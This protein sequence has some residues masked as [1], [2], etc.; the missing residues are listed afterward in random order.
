MKK[1]FLLTSVPLLIAGAWA[2]METPRRIPRTIQGV[3]FT[4]E[5][6]E[7]ARVVARDYEWYEP[8]DMA[9]DGSFTF[10][11]IQNWTGEGENRAALV[12]QW[13]DDE[14]EAAIVFGY[15]WDGVATGADMIR[16][17]VA[18]NPRL[19]ALI[20]YTNVS[21]P[22]DPNGGYTINGF[23]WDRDN[24]GEIALQDAKDKKIYTV[25]NGLFIHPRGYN[26]EVGGSSDYDY[27]DWSST[28]PD[29][30]WGAGWYISYWSYWVKDDMESKFGY[31]GWGASGR[32]LQD[33][34]WDGWN[35]SVDMIPSD[36][37]KFVSA[38]ALIPEGAKTLFENDGISYSLV[39]YSK[40]TVALIAGENGE[41]S[42]EIVIPE[43][44]VDEETGKEYTVTEIKENAFENSAVTSVA[45][46]SSVT[47]IGTG[48]FASSTLSTISGGEGV[49]K[50]GENAFKNCSS[51]T[52]LLLP[53][54]MTNIPAGVYENTAITELVIPDG[55]TSI[56]DRAFAE[57]SSLGKVYIPQGIKEPG[58]QTFSGSAGITEIETPEVYPV[59]L[60]EGYFP[61]EVYEKA[62]V[63]VPVGLTESYKSTAGWNLFMNFNE[64]A[65]EVHIGDIFMSG[66]VTYRVS[67]TEEVPS[68][69]AT[70]CKVDSPDRNSIKAANAAGHK[71]DLTIPESV[72]FQNIGF[73]VTALSDSIFMGATELTSVRIEAPVTTVTAYAFNE[74]EGLTSV[75]LP[76]SVSSVAPWAFAYCSSLT[77]IKLPAAVET[78][79]ERAF[80][81]CKELK[82][83]ELP[84]K[85]TSI[86]DYCFA[87]CQ[88][89]T[90]MSFSDNVTEIGRNIFQNCGALEKVRLPQG[91]EK[92][93]YYM[94]DSCVE[95]K[96]C[97]IPDGVTEIATSAF[98]NCRSLD[99]K[100]P[101]SVT[102]LGT[103]A[104]N[105]CQKITEFTCP[106][107]MTSVPNYLLANCSNLKK[108]VLPATVTA[109]NYG[110][111]MNCTSL[112]EIEVAGQ[113]NPGENMMVFPD[114][115]T[116]IGNAVFSGCS[117]I[118]EFTFPESVKTISSTVLKGAVSLQKVTLSPNSTQLN[119]EALAGTGLK[120]LVIPASV[121]SYSGSNAVYGCEGIRVYVCNPSPAT[122]PTYMWR[123]NSTDFADI[124]VPFGSLDLYTSTSN[125]KKSDLTAPV[126]ASASFADCVVAPDCVTG[127]LIV[128]YDI[129]NLPE[130][131]KAV[132]DSQL[133]STTTVSIRKAGSEDTEECG[134]MLADGS[135]T[136]TLPE[137]NET[138][139]EILFINNGEVIASAK[140]SDLKSPFRF[141]EA[142][143]EAHFDEQFTPEIIF[144]SEEY[145]T[146]DLEYASDN[147]DVAMVSRVG[148]VTVKRTEGTARI[149]ASVKNHPEISA[150]MTV[151]AALRNPVTGFILGN[152]DKD[153]TLDELDILALCP[154]VTP[155]NA[156]IQSYD[157]EISDPEI[158]TTYSVKAFNPLRS[159]FELVTHKSGEFDL[160]F[161]AQDGS[162]VVS[163]YHITVKPLEASQ[164]SDSYQDGTFWLNEDWFGHTNGSINYITKNNEMV[165]RAYGRQNPGESFGCTSQYGII[166]GGKL[167]VMSK[168]ADDGGDPRKGGG[169]VVIADASTLKKLAS[170]DE[171]GGDGRACVGAGAG[172]VYLGTTGGIRIL[173]TEN[174]EL[175]GMIE[176]IPEGSL[177][178]D[179]VG[180]MVQA[181]NL[182]FAIRQNTGVYAIDTD[183]DMV[184]ATF[185]E[186]SSLK[187]PQGIA[188]TADGKVWVASTSKAS[189]GTGYLVCIDPA[190]LEVERTEEMP[191]KMLVT[192]GW[193]A[194][195]STNFFASRDENALWWGSGVDNQ[196][197]S[198]NT[199]YYKW[200]LKTPLSELTP[201]FVFPALDGIDEK[202]KQ[203][204][205]ATV[206]YDERS[207]RLLV[208]ATHGASSNY[209]Y[210]WL[211]F[212]DCKSGEI[213]N[214]I[215]L[216]DYYWFPAIP[217]FP[218]KYA[219]E[220]AEI[221]EIALNLDLSTESY[222]L[223]LTDFVTD[224]DNPDCNIRLSLVETPALF[225]DEASTTPAEARLEGKKLTVTPKSKGNINFTLLAESNGRVT[226]TS[227]PVSVSAIATGLS[228]LNAGSV[229]LTGNR[230]NIKGHE[231]E[232]FV[233]YDMTGASVGGVYV[234]SDNFSI[235]LSLPYGVYALRGV[236]DKS[237]YK[238]IIR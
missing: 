30:F 187:Y 177:Y 51:L 17:V 221:P 148:K 13:N 48:A 204:P 86:P 134:F 145:S 58:S 150:V 174:L 156:D 191:E 176:G 142:L 223:D 11:M 78:I 71:G 135:F 131:F 54:G 192:C 227:V 168:Q 80:F 199:G 160:S 119:M 207:N 108:V 157:I 103:E 64:K 12:I 211:H 82:N 153:I 114:G 115:L 111:F 136:V 63:T 25:E 154:V 116:T 167:I 208:A 34:S 217:I 24:D 50:I 125:W 32:V 75:I 143:Y 172:K 128:S 47:K 126:V 20:Q 43:T 121:K 84:E 210:T 165:Y 46:P 226:Q 94:F 232:T 56:G 140:L 74:C 79:G 193:G 9:G 222:E 185:G 183:Y 129:E 238:F 81:Q 197:Y 206:R 76:S 97:V 15:R 188:M 184:I 130:S 70:Y 22:T 173:D 181:G 141:A 117:A 3:D 164:L 1:V 61:E 26:P 21:S 42:G 175:G 231:G 196:I 91:L 124:T 110:A 212:V 45:I 28:D 4:P 66:G 149:T 93:P 200:D 10:D 162:E 214:T 112:T 127:R 179:Q 90:E 72:T 73:K 194:W 69:V 37:K 171:I 16:A 133:A 137:G 55:V 170:F 151:E 19:Y 190:T 123:I 99:I 201:I 62:V 198:G 166:H 220:F 40:S 31:S 14:E 237:N 180:D 77:D 109:L 39:D 215:R 5:N 233:I 52:T 158:A 234:D 139:D 57:C 186:E 107:G 144:D 18:N 89:L 96:D 92:I 33:G 7:K 189:G 8:E 219:P 159:F 41:Y 85:I 218:D 83:L 38:P 59:A 230:L 101:A 29:D 23:G 235:T 146:A 35:F 132:C 120:E 67:S 236:N 178:A 155:E 44:F 98:K 138:N 209:R 88:G 65:K 161:K 169:R 6:S 106:D 182:V 213:A 113:E 68:V 87:Y 102:T 224:K 105:G 104:F 2:A 27:D 53:A 152:G 195:R 122:V 203:A 95:L 60:P 100:L 163:T 49:S 228:S 205:Y 36:W 202:T 147:T 225:D 229:S 216:K 118:T